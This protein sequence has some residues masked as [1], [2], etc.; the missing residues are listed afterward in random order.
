MTE[1]GWPL[2]WTTTERTP[3]TR[4]EF[5]TLAECSTAKE[6]QKLPWVSG[7]HIV[8]SLRNYACVPLGQRPSI[9]EPGRVWR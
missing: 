4:A 5:R 9:I 7:T 1:M 6:V 8:P 3:T 2:H